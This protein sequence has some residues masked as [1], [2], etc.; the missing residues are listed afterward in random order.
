[1]ITVD[2]LTSLGLRQINPALDCSFS[3]SPFLKKGFL[4]EFQRK[5]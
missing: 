3:F 1:M 4:D 5:A 2:V